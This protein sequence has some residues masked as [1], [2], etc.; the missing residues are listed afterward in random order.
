MKYVQMCWC[1]CVGVDAQGMVVFSFYAFSIDLLV[2][3]S[4]QGPAE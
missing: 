1:G 4:E 3:D 2:Q